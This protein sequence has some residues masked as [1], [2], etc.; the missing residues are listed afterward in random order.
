M[1]V[2]G[3]WGRIRCPTGNTQAKVFFFHR[4]FGLRGHIW[5]KGVMYGGGVYIHIF[6]YIYIHPPLYMNP[7]LYDP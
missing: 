1:Y 2:S 5:G 4:P 3:G 7:P 6:I